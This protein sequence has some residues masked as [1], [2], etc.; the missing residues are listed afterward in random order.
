MRIGSRILSTVLAAIGIAALVPGCLFRPLDRLDDTAEYLSQEVANMGGTSGA[1][2]SGGLGKSLATNMAADT[3]RAD[4]LI[5]PFTWNAA[6]QGWVRTA[7]YTTSE[8]YQRDR[9]DTVWFKNAAGDPVQYPTF[10][11]V[12]TVKHVRHVTH[13]KG[14]NTADILVTINGSLTAA[15]ETTYVKNG[16][17]SGTYNGESCATGTIA[18]VTRQ[19][20]GG[21]WRFPSAGTI[22]ADFPRFSYNV[23]FTGNST[24]QVDIT[25]KRTGNVRETTITV[26]EQ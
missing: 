18:G 7:L 4:L 24:A 13:S 11:T 21:S 10:A 14:D 19:Y 22:T 9:V 5:H 1:M 3:F 15:A 26:S 17:I 20:T 2:M 6:I 12:S 16:T 23:Q 8:G 25:N